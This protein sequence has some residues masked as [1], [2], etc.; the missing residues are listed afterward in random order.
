MT[1]VL[2]P[3]IPAILGVGLR[4]SLGFVFVPPEGPALTWHDSNAR[5]GEAN[6]AEHVLRCREV[7]GPINI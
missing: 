2:L 6:P 4:Y 7:R 1:K 3:A 5:I